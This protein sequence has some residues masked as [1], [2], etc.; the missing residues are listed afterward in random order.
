MKLT[1]SSTRPQTRAMRCCEFPEGSKR[2][3][4]SEQVHMTTVAI[5]IRGVE[6]NRE[7]SRLMVRHNHNRGLAGGWL[8]DGLDGGRH[9]GRPS[10]FVEEFED[11]V[12][13]NADALGGVDQRVGEFA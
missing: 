10:L 1:A 7:R 9:A 5:T 4:S 11:G 2:E 6:K 12:G 3:A 8:R 13:R